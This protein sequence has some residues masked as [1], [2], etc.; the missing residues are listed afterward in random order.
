MT[1][2]QLACKA[3]LDS[4]GDQRRFHDSR[5]LTGSTVVLIAAYPEICWNEKARQS[6]IEIYTDAVR[7]GFVDC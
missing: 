4:L 1:K 2:E 7:N 5:F 6:M 3:M